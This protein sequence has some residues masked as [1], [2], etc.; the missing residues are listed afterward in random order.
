MPAK[1][2]QEQLDEL[3]PRAT[4]V[5]KSSL[6]IDYWRNMC[7]PDLRGLQPR[8]SENGG[9]YQFAREVGRHWRFD[10]CIVEALVAVEVDGGNR[11]AKWSSKLHQCVVVGRHTLDADYEKLNAAAALGWRV[12]RFTPGMLKRDPYGCVQMVAG[13]VTEATA[14]RQ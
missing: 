3:F 7:P 10:W 9:E 2:G 6:W 8:H 14:A 5:D 12:F 11:M 4:A 1:T 13:A